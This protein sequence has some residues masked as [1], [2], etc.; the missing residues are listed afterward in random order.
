M[1]HSNRIWEILTNGCLETF[2]RMHSPLSLI[3]SPCFSCIL[4]KVTKH[5][6]STIVDQW[7]TND[8]DIEY[9]AF[10]HFR[11]WFKPFKPRINLASM[12]NCVYLPTMSEE[13]KLTLKAIP[14]DDWWRGL[15]GSKSNAPPQC[16]IPRWSS[17]H[18]Q[19]IFLA[20]CQDQHGRD[21]PALF[22]NQPFAKITNMIALL[23]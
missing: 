11:N 4:W 21:G 18:H 6:L 10:N 16:P 22:S 17:K 20:Y 8:S 3:L 23:C 12:H 5:T 14:T 1:S 13:T 15:V 9:I 7:K 2:Q 19:Q